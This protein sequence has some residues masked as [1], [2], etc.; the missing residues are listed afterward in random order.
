M[1]TSNHSLIDFVVIVLLLLLFSVV[2]ETNGTTV[3]GVSVEFLVLLSSIKMVVFEKKP[4]IVPVECANDD[5]TV[6]VDCADVSFQDVVSI[7]SAMLITLMYIVDSS[8]SGR[9]R[10]LSETLRAHDRFT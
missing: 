1:L 6:S 10:I 7:T 2:V 8:I 5:D 3:S 4:L 9:K